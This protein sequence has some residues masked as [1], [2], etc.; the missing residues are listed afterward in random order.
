M[1][2][3]SYGKCIAYWKR[4]VIMV[5]GRG[6]VTVK[7]RLSACLPHKVQL[8]SHIRYREDLKCVIENRWYSRVLCKDGTH[9][10]QVKHRVHTHTQWCTSTHMDFYGLSAFRNRRCVTGRTRAADLSYVTQRRFPM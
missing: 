9:I 8:C 5:C 3:T 10:N 7:G 6:G 2:H 1:Q 4:S